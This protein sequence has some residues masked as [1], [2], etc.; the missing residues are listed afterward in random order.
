MNRSL[1]SSKTYEWSTPQW[2]FDKLNAVHHFDLDVCASA[3]NHKCEYYFDK[4]QDGL[5][6]E[7]VGTVWMN[8]PYG[9]E[10]W[11]WVKKACEYALCRGARLYVCFP[12]AQIPHG[13]TIM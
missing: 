12:H 9:R 11:K 10:I 1:F 3:E 4:S 2:L 7:W 5:S 8:P 6:R 13:G